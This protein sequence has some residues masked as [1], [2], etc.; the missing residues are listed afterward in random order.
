MVNFY[1]LCRLLGDLRHIGEKLLPVSVHLASHGGQ[2]HSQSRH[3]LPAEADNA[4]DPRLHSLQLI[5]GTQEA[6]LQP[7]YLPALVFNLTLELR[8]TRP[9]VL[10]ERPVRGRGGTVTTN[11]NMFLMTVISSSYLELV[12]A[13]LELPGSA[14]ELLKLTFAFSLSAF[15]TSSSST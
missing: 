6:A 11:M 14:L 2:L 3:S 5:L 4:G 7:L 15:I 10:Q 1:T 13:L 8:L 12:L 9:L